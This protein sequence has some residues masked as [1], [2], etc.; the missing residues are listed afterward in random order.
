MDRKEK[1]HTTET[2]QGSRGSGHR[3]RTFC[4]VQSSLSFAYN[5]AFPFCFER[6]RMPTFC[7]TPAWPIY[8]SGPVR[9]SRSI[10]VFA[11]LGSLSFTNAYASPGSVDSNPTIELMARLPAY[12]EGLDPPIDNVVLKSTTVTTPPP[13]SPLPTPPPS[14]PSPPSPPTLPPQAAPP[15]SS[16]TS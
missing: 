15:H 16:L 1:V 4:G 10:G 12:L 5:A 2:T 8:A 11:G 6:A 14:S 7:L 3:I 9:L 13:S